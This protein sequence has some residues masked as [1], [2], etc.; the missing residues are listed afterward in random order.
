VPSETPTL[1][2][3]PAPSSGLNGGAI[4]G[5]VVGVLVFLVLL[6]LGGLLVAKQRRN[7]QKSAVYPN[8]SEMS[9]DKA[10]PGISEVHGTSRPAELPGW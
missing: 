6:V 9:T 7:R 3:L 4:A 8:A 10:N 2:P 1:E 5:I